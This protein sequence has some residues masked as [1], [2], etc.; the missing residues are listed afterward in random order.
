MSGRHLRYLFN[1][2]SVALIGASERPGSLGEALARKLSAGGFSGPL[3]WINR[4]HHQIG[5]RPA[6]RRLADLPDAPELAIIAT[7][8]HAVPDLLLEAGRRGVKLAVIATPLSATSNGPGSALQRALHKAVRD[9]GLRVLGPDAGFSVPPVGLDA[10]LAPQTPAPGALALVSQSQAAIGPLIGWANDRELGFSQIVSVGGSSDLAVPDLLDSLIDDPGTQV[11]LLMVEDIGRVRPFLSAARAL[12]RAKPVLALRVSGAGDAASRQR[13]ALYDAAFRRIGVL[14]LPSPRELLA[15]AALL[16]SH[17]TSQGDRLTVIGNSRF[18][19]RLA[20]DRLLAEG[21][22]LARLGEEAVH[23]L[24]HLLPGGEW[25]HNPLDLGADA[26]A[27]RYAAALKMVLQERDADGVLVFHAPNSRVSAEAVATAVADTVQRQWDERGERRPSVLAAWVTGDNNPAIGRCWRERGIP[28]YETLEDA[29]RAFASGW[30]R[31]Q[32]RIGL[33][34][35]PAVVPELSAAA[36]AAARQ[37]V[38]ST[39]AA[40]R[41]ELEAAEAAALLGAYGIEVALGQAAPPIRADGLDWPGWSLRL[42]EDALFGPVLWLEAAERFDGLAAPIAL[43]PPLDLALAREAI[44]PAPLYRALR[45]AQ[46]AAP[47]ALDR[48]LALLVKASRLIVDRAEIIDLELNNLKLSGCGASV[49]AVRIRLAATESPPHRRLA[50][51]PY[52]RELEETV[53]LPDGS[54]LLIRPVRAEDEPTFIESFKQLSTEEVRMRFMHTVKE[55]THEEAARLTQIDYG[56][57]MALVVFRQRP[58]QPLESCGVARL[59]RDNHDSERAEFAIVLLRAATGIGLGSLLLR[60]LIRY[61]RARGF[62]ELFGEILRENEPMLA[63][64]RAMGFSVAVCPDDAGVMIARLP[65][66]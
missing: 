15:T 8:E 51:C 24:C 38:E 32:N 47:G 42:V 19:G 66:V 53:P 39:L 44:R 6:Y 40:G 64:C 54:T 1:P 12:A 23:A 26:S 28:S 16:A 49:G 2:A 18:L 34:A 31:Q 20:A 41:D 22:R 7:P 60:R 59:M 61:A 27:D 48:L 5:E 25:P 4:Q 29:A 62:R 43:F 11:V 10:L 33:M 3:Y 36:R 46:T 56:R 14:R 58:D 50:I 57:E 63:L 35:T 30:R 45:D 17:G 13:D 21:G 37:V 55:L 9:S 65:L 52:P